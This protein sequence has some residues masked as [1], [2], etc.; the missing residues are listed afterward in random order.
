MTPQRFFSII[1]NLK[2]ENNVILYDWSK[3]YRIS[4]GQP[5]RILAILGYLTYPSI[6]RRKKD[7][8]YKLSQ[9]DWTGES[10]LLHPEK[11][12]QARH[13]FSDVEL[14][15]YVALASFRS[16][17]ALKATNDSTLPLELCPL[18]TD[19]V[20]NSRLLTVTNN[21]VYFCW[22]EVTQ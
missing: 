1:F 16:L 2:W 8:F 20:S 9:T 22:E 17:A 19:I 13:K 6:P 14:A 5:S 12:V 15:E 18:N 10:Y 3:I 4:E 21:K 7:P 11:V